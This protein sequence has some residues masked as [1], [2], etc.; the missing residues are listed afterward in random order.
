ML[1]WPI[2]A[3]LALSPTGRPRPDLQRHRPLTAARYEGIESLRSAAE[4][5]PKPLMDK[6]TGAISV[7][8]GV[9]PASPQTAAAPFLAV[10]D[11]R[12]PLARTAI[13]L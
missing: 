13:I 1:P 7:E 10:L 9:E 4:Q 11:L 3:L 12:L 5:V 6:T 2:R 8:K